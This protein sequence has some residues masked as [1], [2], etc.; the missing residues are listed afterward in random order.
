MAGSSYPSWTHINNRW[1][2]LHQIDLGAARNIQKSEIWEGYGRDHRPVAVHVLLDQTHSIPQRNQSSKGWKPK[3][4]VI[5]TDISERLSAEP[6][7]NTFGE[8]EEQ[9]RKICLSALPHIATGNN[10]SMRIQTLGK[11]NLCDCE[12]R[13]LPRGTLSDMRK[14]GSYGGSVAPSGDGRPNRKHLLK[15]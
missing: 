7:I 1:G 12:L 13:L 8:Y 4:D 11:C 6:D 9:L 3:N 15:P 5:A 14:L 10:P 2:T